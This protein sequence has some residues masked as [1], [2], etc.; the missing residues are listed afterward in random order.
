VPL[1]IKDSLEEQV[2]EEPRAN[3][4]SQVHVENAP[5]GGGY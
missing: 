5:G 1:I 3:Q 4:L 2:E